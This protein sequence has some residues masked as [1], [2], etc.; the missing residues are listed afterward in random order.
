MSDETTTDENIISN[1]T[2]LTRIQALVVEILNNLLRAPIE[3]TDASVNEAIARLGDYCQRD[4]TYVFVHHGEITQ[5]THEWCAEGID[6]M[7]DHLQEL[8]IELYG[9]IAEDLGRG[10]VVH[11]PD[12]NELPPDSPSR[13]TLEE[14]S[15]RSILL[16]PMRSEGST[17][18][19]VGFDGVHKTHS[20]LPGEVYLLQS[21]ADVICSVL[22]RREQ[23]TDMRIAQQ[24]LAD[25]RAFL[26]SITSTSAMGIVVIDA[27]GIINFVNNAAES[28]LG[29]PSEQMLGSHHDDPTWFGY[30]REDGTTIPAGETPF[31]VAMRSGVLAP[32]ER[33]QL[34]N[35]DGEHFISVHAAPVVQEGATRPRVVY[36]LLD[37]TDQIM[38]E[39][40]REE[41]L[42]EANRANT[43]KSNFLAKMSHEMRTPLNGVLGVAEVLETLISD[44]DQRRM[45]KVM[46]ESGAL[47]LSIIND[48][49]DMSKIEADLMEIEIVPFIPGELAQRIESV[50]TLKAS[51]KRI[52]FAVNV[53]GDG[54]TAR[55]GDPHRILQ[56]MHNVVSNAIKFTEN[57]SVYVDIDCRTAGE[58]TLSVRDSGI[59]MTEAQLAHLF[60][61]FGQADSSI[62]RRFGGTG[63]GMPIVNRLVQMMQGRIT[64]ETTPNVG[65]TISVTLPV[66]RTDALDMAMPA[67]NPLLA[68]PDLQAL[69]V[70]A[71]DDN[72]TNRMI[73]AAMMGQLGIAA[74]LVNDGTEALDAY[75]RE[76]FDLV[77]L[78]IS[79]PDMDGVAVQKE[80]RAREAKRAAEDEALAAAK[81]LP[82]VAFT[83][84][85]MAHQVESYIRE[86]FDDC[87]T[88]PLHLD[89]LREA[90][91]GLIADRGRRCPVPAGGVVPLRRSSG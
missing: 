38:A 53:A 64:V 16:V 31:D 23:D 62:A 9:P 20:F 29:V 72:R 30:K 17:Y 39:R 48:L 60:E 74:V 73:L 26:S 32:V 86:G 28:M 58:M 37:V 5:N 79:M 11:V 50:H 61:D 80:I 6:P 65:T 70:L 22:I 4:R 13:L 8:P 71:A 85:A 66:A 56:I 91:S 54:D 69:R 36:A 88:K 82:I 67:P 63:L 47:L 19:F 51:E 49:L 76:A 15:V 89:R 7:I 83:A 81:P 55:L 34:A 25:E 77:I 43:A 87:L 21:V 27:D 24:D 33:L 41:A 78:D 14:Q 12:V 10:D 68:A 44:P 90:L 75:E 84:N 1:E 57:G 18:G 42:D 3:Q 35:R 59:G 40:K 46:H 45:V 52:S 2:R